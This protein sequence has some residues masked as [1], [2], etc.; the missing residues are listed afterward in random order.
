VEGGEEKVK[1]WGKRGEGANER[2]GGGKRGVGVVILGFGP[3]IDSPV[4]C[5]G[6][7]S[8]VSRI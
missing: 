1:E 4:L 3:G 6:A 5:H 7:P 2:G 8:G